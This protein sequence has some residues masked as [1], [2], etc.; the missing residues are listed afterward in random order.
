MPDARTAQTIASLFRPFLRDRLA[1][2]R[3]NGRG[4]RWTDRLEGDRVPCVNLAQP[5]GYPARPSGEDEGDG[6]D[7][8][9][10]PCTAQHP[11]ASSDQPFSRLIV[12]WVRP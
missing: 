2:R 8:R 7:E 11:T 3:T 6:R 9:E 5:E 10:Q 12:P 1:L 4:R